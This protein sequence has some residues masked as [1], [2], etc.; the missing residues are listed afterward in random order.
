MK[1]IMSVRKYNK[2]NVKSKLI[3]SVKY[4]YWRDG[5]VG[6]RRH[7]K[8]VISSEAWVRIPLS[9]LPFYIYLFFA[10][11]TVFTELESLRKSVGH[12]FESLY[13]LVDD[14]VLAEIEAYLPENKTKN[15][16]TR[17]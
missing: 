8:A 6:L 4:T 14:K 1:I 3:C 12:Y 5:R 7:V 13:F 9:S 2:N 10:F 17:K 11:Y 15:T 16:T